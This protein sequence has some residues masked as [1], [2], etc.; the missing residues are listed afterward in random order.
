MAVPW[1]DHQ[2]QQQQWSGVN[3]SLENKLYVLQ[4]EEMGEW[5]KPFG[6]A[7]KIMIESPILDPEVFV[8]LEFGFA[9]FPC[10]E[11]SLWKWQHIEFNFAFYKNSYKLKDFEL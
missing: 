11:W 7:Q 2:N 9:L 5:L 4:S 8:L 1:H 6:E 3:W 10:P